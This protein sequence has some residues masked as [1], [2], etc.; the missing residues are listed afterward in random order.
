MSEP[1]KTEMMDIR[2]RVI[3][4]R[5]RQRV[6]KVHNIDVKTDLPYQDVDLNDFVSEALKIRDAEMRTVEKC[7]LYLSPWTKVDYPTKGY[8]MKE[9]NMGD[10]RYKSILI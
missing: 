10:S 7:Q 1:I 8:S 3:G 5:K 4:I 2:M 9:V 6:V